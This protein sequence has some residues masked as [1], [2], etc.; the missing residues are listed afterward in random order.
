M[1]RISQVIKPSATVLLTGDGGD[2][3]FLGYPGHVTLRAERLA[4]TGPASAASQGD[5]RAALPDNGS[6]ARMTLSELCNWRIAVVDANPGCRCRRRG[7]L[8]ARLQ[9]TAIEERSVPSPS[10]RRATS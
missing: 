3:V 10:N 8:G 6:L 5:T 1:L 2:D 7:V 4:R 9:T